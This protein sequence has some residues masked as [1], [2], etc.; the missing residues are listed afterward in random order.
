MHDANF[1]AAA[2]LA[3]LHDDQLLAVQEAAEN[4]LQQS[5]LAAHREGALID[6]LEIRERTRRKGEVFDT[7]LYVE[8]SDRSAYRVAGSTSMY[9]L[10]AEGLRLGS[11]R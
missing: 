10:Y 9:D 3:D 8:I 7:A 6:L 11:P 4:R 2:L 1:D 5:A